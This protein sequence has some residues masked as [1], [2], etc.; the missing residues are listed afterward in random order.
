[1]V[2]QIYDAI[3]VR[4]DVF[5]QSLDDKMAPSLGSVY[6]GKEHE[7]YT[8][9]REFFER[10]LITRNML[11]VLEKVAEGLTKTSGKLITLNSTFGGG[12]THTLLT[13]YHSVNSPSMLTLAA[14]EEIGLEDL[15]R[16][17]NLLE[18]AS[19]EGVVSIVIDGHIAETAP[20][21]IEPL[22]VGGAEIRTLW[23]Y[24]AYKLGRYLDYKKY[25]EALVPPSVD[26]L[27]ELF[28][29]K[30]VLLLIDEIANYISKFKN[31][32][33]ETLRNYAKQVYVF[34][35]NLAK[36]VESTQDSRLVVI[37]SLPKGEKEVERQYEE[38]VREISRALGRIV[39]PFM[40]V[41]PKDFPKILRV[42]LFK[43]VNLDKAKEVYQA[44][45]NVFKEWEEIFGEEAIN[46]FK[47]FETVYPFHPD[48][49]EVLRKIVENHE[50]LQKTRDA[51][52]LA[53][54]VIRKLFESK[55]QTSLV[56][57]YHL[58]P[59][60][61]LIRGILFRERYEPFNQ[62]IE[63]DISKRSKTYEYPELASNIAK[64][65]LLR[66]FVF[67]GAILVNPT[68]LPN[69]KEVIRAT[70]EIIASEKYDW[71]P[72]EYKRALEWLLNNTG[73]MYEKDGRIWFDTLKDVKRLIEEEAQNVEEDEAEEELQAFLEKA[74]SVSRDDLLKVIKRG[75]PRREEGVLFKGNVEVLS[76]A[77]P[78]DVDEPL[79]R[80]LILLKNAN[81]DE[82]YDLIFKKANGE[83]IYANTIYVTYV[84]SY[85]RF[86]ETLDKFKEFIACK[87]I[88]EN[89]RSYFPSL[90]SE[91]LE[92]IKS[93]I[94]KS[95]REKEENAIA[96]AYSLF[97]TVAYPSFDD[98]ANMKAVK[99][100]YIS[101]LHYSIVV[102]V[103]RKLAEEG[104]LY[105]REYNTAL[106]FDVLR[107][108]IESLGITLFGKTL[109][110]IMEYFLTNP[111]LPAIPKEELRESLREALENRKIGIERGGEVYLN[112]D[113]VERVC[114]GNCKER[115]VS[116]AFDYVKDED[117]VLDIVEAFKRFVE[118]ANPFKENM[119]EEREEVKGDKIRK[120][121]YLVEVEGE[122][123][124]PRELL[125]EFSD[126]LEEAINSINRIVRVVE[127]IESGIDVSVEPKEVV[128]EPNEELE[129]E[130]TI[131]SVGK[132]KG[133]VELE[134]DEG[135]VEPKKVML[136]EGA[137]KSVLWRLR[138][139]E[140]PGE[141][142]YALRVKYDDNVKEYEVKVIVQ[143][144]EELRQGI[145][146][147]AQYLE[148]VSNDLKHF[149]I[150]KR[151]LK[152]SWNITYYRITVS[153]RNTIVTSEMN[154]PTWEQAELLTKFLIMKVAPRPSEIKYVMKLQTQTPQPLPLSE[155]E[156]EA[157][158]G[159]LRY[160]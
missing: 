134:V 129:F 122:E 77:K 135:E 139:P 152:G 136:E 21:P 46:V 144:K 103:E 120:I 2:V 44:Y 102:N 50:N 92:I 58:D 31:S 24:L 131:S 128:V 29:G 71:S 47:N 147:E 119:L 16:V 83:R 88:Q 157:L 112:L 114:E 84:D 8:N 150:L 142:A 70:Y 106:S 138:A 11:S 75:R 159:V 55:E 116:Q 72:P 67:K 158:S 14:T 69:D 36:A 27:M 37:V 5:D 6:L 100:D 86:R 81:Q 90:T 60:D 68:L 95:C 117:V 20:S 115:L 87:K 53:R 3:K 123:I 118:G 32:K 33:D 51:I 26:K 74:Y 43:E 126:Q 85:E 52:R 42:R 125:E 124:P 4:D 80:L 156:K 56:M 49:V 91:E 151:R 143:R 7:I 145:P 97:R 127:V 140:V 63:E 19:R 28:K 61:D 78:L 41:S 66:T 35:E 107:H 62:V 98:N 1:V 94:V 121:K 130:V 111:K 17:K 65:V 105:S 108:L 79:Y 54:I 38:V 40:P 96:S 133:E 146:Q 82:L 15:N 10:T 110:Q 64:Y 25:D 137:S 109:S 149:E 34:L 153:S 18:E 132:F 155:D 45:V 73:Y 39:L 113:L 57:P 148:V 93:K 101:T 89:I 13:I 9:P 22:Q 30:R 23:G 141:Y 104:K 154:N 160:R 59:E 99:T 48:F 76:D 12:K